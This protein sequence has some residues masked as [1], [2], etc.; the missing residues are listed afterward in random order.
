MKKSIGVKLDIEGIHA[1]K[2]C[3]IEE[4]MYLK[5]PHRHT[6]QILCKIEVAHGD[7][8]IEFIEFK[9]AVKQYIGQTWFNTKIGCCDF[10]S[11]S[12]EM[13]AENLLK[14]FELAEC[15]VSE[16]GEFFGIVTR[17]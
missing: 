11:M 13:I 16:D 8:A 14:R 3:N 5:Y 7:R 10:G 15:S 2:D 1:W 17:D 6:F 12:C 9:H 4:V